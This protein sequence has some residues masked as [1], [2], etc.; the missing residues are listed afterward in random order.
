MKWHKSSHRDIVK[1]LLSNEHAIIFVQQVLSG[2]KSIAIGV[3]AIS[4]VLYLTELKK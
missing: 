3:T 1:L 4:S 2:Q